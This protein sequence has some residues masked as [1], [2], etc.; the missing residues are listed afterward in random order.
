MNW[1]VLGMTW[2]YLGLAA[3]SGVLLGAGWRELSLRRR[4][5][6]TEAEFDEQLRKQVAIRDSKILALEGQV[7]EMKAAQRVVAAAPVQ[8]A[9]VSIATSSDRVYEE[10]VREPHGP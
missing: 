5:K 1:T 9:L 2:L 6:Q 10:L 7:H 8:T 4:W 3:L